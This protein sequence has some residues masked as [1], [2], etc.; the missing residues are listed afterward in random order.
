MKKYQKL[1]KSTS[2]GNN[3]IY[4]YMPITEL[5]YHW[6][7]ATKDYIRQTASVIYTV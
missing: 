4:Q 3:K 1:I 7:K 6:C 5:L 2:I